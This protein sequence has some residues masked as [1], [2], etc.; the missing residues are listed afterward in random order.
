MIG[1][2]LQSYEIFRNAGEFL[3]NYLRR[4]VGVRIGEIFLAVLKI[5]VWYQKNFILT[6]TKFSLNLQQISSA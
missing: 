2:T 6:K 5:V 1:I 3:E 4:A